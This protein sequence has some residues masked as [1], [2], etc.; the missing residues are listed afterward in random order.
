MNFLT[1]NIF[2]RFTLGP[3]LATGFAFR[4]D[5]LFLNCGLFFV[6]IVFAHVCFLFVC[7]VRVSIPLGKPRGTLT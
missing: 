2:G 5:F 7:V 6:V 1:L 3:Y 4:G